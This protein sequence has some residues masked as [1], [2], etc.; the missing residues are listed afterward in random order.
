MKVLVLG[1]TKISYMPYMN[2]YIEQLLKTN[3]KIHLVY[4]ARD[5][6]PDIEVPSEIKTYCF[7]EPMLDSKPLIKKIPYFIKYRNFVKKI[8]KNNKFELIIVLHSTP[9][10][11]LS[12]ILIRKFKG[13]YIIDYRDFTYENISLYKKVVHKLINNSAITFV[14]SKGYLKFLPNSD[15]IYISHNLQFHSHDERNV[16]RKKPR[17]N[18]PIRI[19]FWGLIRHVEINKQIINRLGNDKRF[20]LHYHGREQKSG[21]ILRKYVEENSI[22]NVFFHGEY[23]PSERIDFASKTDLLHNIYENDIKTKYAMANKFYDGITFYLPQLCNKNSLMG[24]EVESN[25]LGIMVDPND[26]NFADAIYEY[27]KNIDWDEFNLKCEIKLNKIIEEYNHG[28][29]ILNSLLSGK[30]VK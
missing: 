19:R 22:N 21:Q 6:N 18:N 13:K 15:N 29:D 2:F 20:E 5:L 27:Y 28:K 12:D 26:N 4:W 7:K 10:V 24:Q 9:G 8:I 30:K 23:R 17:E 11:L 1:F 3:C 16:R 25:G 14:S